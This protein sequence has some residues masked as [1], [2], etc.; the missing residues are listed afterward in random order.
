M[1]D[2]WG[3]K[4]SALLRFGL[5]GPAGWDARNLLT[6]AIG[7]EIQVATIHDVYAHANAYVVRLPVGGSRLATKTGQVG[8]TPLGAREIT[9]LQVGD[10]VVCYVPKELPYCYILAVLPPQIFDA[11]F[12][13]PDSLVM[14]SGVGL[15]EDVMHSLGFQDEQNNMGNFSGGRPADTLQ[16]DW[17]YINELGVAVWL[18]KLMTSMRASDIAKIEMFWGDDLV[19]IF[20]WNLQKYTAGSEQSA[21]D[22]EGEYVE[23][24][25]WTPFQSESLGSYEPGVEVFED[26]DGEAGGL[27]RGGEKCKFEGRESRQSMVFRGLELKGYVGDAVRRAIVLLPADGSGISRPDDDKR[28]RGA[29][30]EHVGLDGGYHLRS[31]KEIIF[32]KTVMMPVPRQLRDPDDPGGDTKIDGDYPKIGEQEKKPYEWSKDDKPDVRHMELW[33]YQAYLFGK[34]GL[35]VVDA[36]AKD[37]AAPEEGEVGIADDTENRIDPALF[38][39]LDHVF[40]RDLPKYGRV[41]IDQRIGHETRYYQ[42]KAGLYMLD[43]GSVVIEDGYGSQLVMSGGNIHV[44]CQG[45]IFNRPGRSFITWAPR[46]FIGRAG[47]CAELSSAKKDVRIKAEENLHLLANDT[48]KGS[49]LIESKAT[50]RSKR[51]GWT[52][53]VGEDIEDGGIIVK[54]EKS[55]IGLWTENL[56]GGVHEDGDGKVEFNAGSG[57]AV[58][59]GGRVG[60]EALS[61]WSV[62]VGPERS[63]AENPA[64]MTL[65][66]GEAV[67]RVSLDITGGFLGV[68]SG[69]GGAGDIKA[70]GEIGSRAGFRT[71][72]VCEAN[73]H[74]VGSG[75]PFVSKTADYRLTPNPQSRRNQKEDSADALKL[76]IFKSFEDDAFNDPEISL[77]RKD[78]WDTVGFSFRLTDTHIKLDGAFQVFESRWQQLYRI[79]GGVT[80]WDEPKVTSPGGV[81]TRPHPGEKGWTQPH[82]NYATDGKNVDLQKGIARD[83]ESQVEQ[84]SAPTTGTLESQYPIN[85]QE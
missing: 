22:D 61:E 56:F 10:S 38:S 54:A 29:F 69:T 58:M 48:V 49:I 47:W 46:D 42:A 76:R 11:R 8:F 13:L 26:N 12:A 17:G 50:A 66:P 33:E 1:P 5:L 34:Y 70:E 41:V 3:A 73:G 52:G 59:A 74:F 60:H 81:D 65:R 20:G 4:L 77:G 44:T 27:K 9:H 53:K 78:F 31:A 51:S 6:S 21:F 71:E 80:T 75:S 18:G 14:R 35:Q 55:S 15:I 63:D 45:D 84:G 57:F 36:H 24:G 28:Y 82:Y 68:W 40:S 2:D 62:M 43:D 37:W 25:R 79:F 23:V 85:V 67:L 39:K 7:R 30:E 16:G 19:R 83:R 72:G 64:Q 32:E